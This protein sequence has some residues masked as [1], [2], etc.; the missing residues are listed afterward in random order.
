MGTSVIASDIGG[1]R[2]SLPRALHPYLFTPG[3]Y[4]ELLARLSAVMA[5]DETAL[6]KLAQTARR[7]V[8]EHYDIR[9]VNRKLLARLT[10]LI[11]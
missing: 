9:D 11:A 1:I 10:S 3:S 4:Q 8:E 7:F 2:E 6:R 5:A